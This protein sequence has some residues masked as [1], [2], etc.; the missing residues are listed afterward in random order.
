MSD[1]LWPHGLQHA[2]PLCPSPTPRAC[3]NSC[4]LSWW[5]HPA[6]SSSVVPFSSCPQSLPAS[7]SFPKSQLFASGDPSIATSAS[8]SLRMHIQ[9]WF[10]VGLTG[11]ISLLSKELSRVFSSTTVRMEVL[12]VKLIKRY[13]KVISVIYIVAE[14]PLVLNKKKRRNGWWHKKLFCVKIK[15]ISV[16]WFLLYFPYIE[17]NSSISKLWRLQWL[18]DYN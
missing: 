13:P 5:C 1:S 6:I 9:G 2:R 16:W 17:G 4:P 15:H 3:S 7:G 11:L 12:K 18:L 10:P 14:L 8:A